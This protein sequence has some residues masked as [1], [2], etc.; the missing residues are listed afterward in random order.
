[1][2]AG[3][4]WDARIFRGVGLPKVFNIFRKA[5]AELAYIYFMRKERSANI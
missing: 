1:M 4:F 3:D 2:Q 5:N